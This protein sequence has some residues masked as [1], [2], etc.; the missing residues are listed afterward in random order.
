MIRI[1]NAWAVAMA[2]GLG[3]LA[4]QAQAEVTVMTVNL[5]DA[6]DGYY[7]TKEANKKLRDAQEK[8]QEQIEALNQEGN[9]L[10]E[11]YQE[12]VEQSKNTALTE[13]ARRKAGEDSQKKLEEIQAK[14]A[15]VTQFGQNTQRALAQRQKTHRDLMFDEI[16][17]VVADMAKAKGA[18]L[19]FDSSGPSVFGAP[20]LLYG[21]A[22]YDA[23]T[24]LLAILNKDAPPG[25]LED[26]PVAP[27]AN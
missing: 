1:R 21:D 9:Q 7:K 23:T 10:V 24:E 6:Y 11:S 19:V 22:S 3:V 18:T 8:A 16:T 17:K 2:V 4:G 13:E 26:D 20:V 5:A 27:A 14:Q 12:M 25:S 15:E